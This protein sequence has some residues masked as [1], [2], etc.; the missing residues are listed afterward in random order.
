MSRN[1]HE[2]FNNTM[3]RIHRLDDKIAD[4]EKKKKDSMDKLTNAIIG[5][6]NR[7]HKDWFEYKGIGEPWV[8][9]RPGET[10]D[11]PITIKIMEFYDAD[12]NK[13]GLVGGIWVT[14]TIN[15]NE[16]N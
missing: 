10:K 13:G 6:I 5:W 11:D 3:S 8:V 9:V 12:K 16:L 14:R 1:T 2:V 15:P 7:N 4:I